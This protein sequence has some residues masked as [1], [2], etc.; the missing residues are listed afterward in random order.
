MRARLTILMSLAGLLLPATAA[1][2]ADR[3]AGKRGVTHSSSTD[4]V[5]VLTRGDGSNPSYFACYRR[6][7]RMRFL[8]R[9]QVDTYVGEI[10]VRGRFLKFEYAG[11][12]YDATLDVVVVDVSRTR[13]LHRWEF[14]AYASSSVPPVPLEVQ[15]ERLRGD[16]A[17]AFLVSGVDANVGGPRAAEVHWAH[18]RR[19]ARLDRGAA[20]DPASFEATVGEIRWR[21]AG[22]ARWAPFH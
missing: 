12:R 7:G 9:D 16:G 21:H 18:G 22:E 11:G 13:E 6:S 20:I 14:A 3:C 2:A 15:G 10:V 4:R 8:E 1:H 19:R 5:R 17:Y